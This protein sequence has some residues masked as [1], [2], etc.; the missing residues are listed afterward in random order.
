MMSAVPETNCPVYVPSDPTAFTVAFCK[1]GS[2]VVICNVAYSNAS[3]T[4]Y[5]LPVCT[6][7]LFVAVSVPS[8]DSTVNNPVTPT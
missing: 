1:S 7:T 2:V 4:V 5:V 6:V 8:E 3:A